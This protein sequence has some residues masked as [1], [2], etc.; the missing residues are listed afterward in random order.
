M[1]AQCAVRAEGFRAD[2]ADGEVLLAKPNTWSNSARPASKWK[3]AYCQRVCSMPSLSL[4][5]RGLLHVLQDLSDPYGRV[6]WGQTMLAKRA[7]C[8]D[9][10][11][12]RLL[13]NLKKAGLL[14]IERQTF[15]SLTAAQE[16]LGL[17]V[18]DRKD[19]GRA[20][21]LL[22]LLVDGRPASELQLVPR[23]DAK[24]ATLRVVQDKPGQDEPGPSIVRAVPLGQS[25]QGEPRTKPVETP[26][27]KMAD[28]LLVSVLVN[29]KVEEDLTRATRPTLDVD[30][31]VQTIVAPPSNSAETPN[32]S[33]NAYAWRALNA[34]YDAHYRHAYGLTPTN[35]CTLHD[36]K[37]ALTMCL[38]EGTD[39]FKK[40]LRER[41]VDVE[42][43]ETNPLEMLA[44][45]ALRAW[46]DLKGTNKY[47]DRRSH[48]MSALLADLPY[49]LREA[50][51]E[52]VE[53]HAPKP[54]PR[55][56]IA[57]VSPTMSRAE[58]GVSRDKLASP[59]PGRTVPRDGSKT[60]FAA[61]A[62]KLVQGLFVPTARGEKSSVRPS[63]VVVRP[64]EPLPNC[65]ETERILKGLSA[66]P[67]LCEFAGD[68][69]LPNELLALARER[70][71]GVERVLGMLDELNLVVLRLGSLSKRSKTNAVYA[72]VWRV[73]ARMDERL[74][75]GKHGK[76]NDSTD[77]AAWATGTGLVENNPLAN[78]AGL[79]FAPAK[80]A[81]VDGD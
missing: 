62:R 42:K 34:A 70:G 60:A 65:P 57:L 41:K 25:V 76:T 16:A 50:M 27:D 54:A 69:L 63:L 7:G 75:R 26:P 77:V 40:R 28:D 29:R 56:V 71:M 23:G 36:E 64:S 19:E 43:L 58:R 3:F 67:A 47:L 61:E 4:E 10:T 9:R 15:K 48:P 74:G 12:R 21:D 66:R 35:K 45:E 72:T 51:K 13:P 17:P 1:V 55:K 30:E 39:L 59:P 20:P 78:A 32:T 6:W 44:N 68:T 22:T 14:R 33:P 37:R 49:R 2:L 73:F 5:H 53:R 31:K 11:L 18:P 46:F 38:R 52:L 80:R 8:S 24:R 81:G 79:G